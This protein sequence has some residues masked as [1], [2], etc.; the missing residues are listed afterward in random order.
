MRVLA[1]V[2]VLVA[3]VGALEVKIQVRAPYLGFT[4]HTDSHDGIGGVIFHYFLN[5][6]EETGLA[7]QTRDGYAYRT[8][9][10]LDGVDAVFAFAEVY[11]VNGN[12]R[13]TTQRAAARV[14]SQD[15]GVTR[16]PSRQIRAATIFRDDFN[17]FDRS[18]WTPEVSMYGGMNGE[19]QVYTNDPKNIYTRNGN[20]YLH[21]IFTT[22]DSRFDE[23]FLHHGRMD[24]QSLFGTCTQSARYGCSRDGKYGLL[25]PIMSGKVKSVPTLRFGTVEVRAKIPKG[26]WIWPAIW[27]LPRSNRYGGWPRSG[28]IDIM[29]SRGNSGNYGVGS[30]SSTLHWGPDGGQNR[31]SMTTGAK[32]TGSWHDSFHTWRLE[33]TPDHLIT[34]V[35]NQQIMRVDPPGGG[36]WQMGN[37][38]GG[39]IWGGNKM[40]PFD[41]DFYMIFNVAVG[42]TNGFFP[43][44][45]DNKPW[46]NG[47]GN[48]VE[49]FWNARSRW[50]NSWQGDNVAM[51]VDYV[52]FKSL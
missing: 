50:Q 31:Y 52:E 16:L 3:V 20:L 43:D 37:F 12:H 18:K 9:A 48:A 14:V 24:M 15:T 44:G 32:H 6:Q 25:P 36:F 29:E 28:E 2:L 11:D 49:N 35:D 1:A 8:R 5:G 45:R 41:Q 34:Y 51:Q 40:A 22:S 4:L 17:N 42:G 39:N 13:L 19:F 27:M 33:W 47:D 38:G 23:N 10:D 30:V 21:P 46:N 26:D 7:T